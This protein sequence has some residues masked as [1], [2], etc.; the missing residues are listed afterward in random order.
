MMEPS[1]ETE[2]LAPLEL[3]SARLREDEARLP[4]TAREG[5]VGYLVGAVQRIVNT[6]SGPP[7]EERGQESRRA[8]A[9][10][11]KLAAEAAAGR[12]EA[13]SLEGDIKSAEIAERYAN[14]RLLNAQ[15]AKVEEETAWARLEKAISVAQMLGVSV[16]IATLADGTPA[17][18]LGDA[19]TISLINREERGTS[20]EAAPQ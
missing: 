9:Q 11:T 1:D 8:I 13:A 20:D 16:D 12:L 6:L 7:S 14:A 17:V 2:E 18:V 3:I 10:A 15:A 5:I 19:T 4:A